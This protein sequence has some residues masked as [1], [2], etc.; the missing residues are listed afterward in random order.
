MDKR[1]NAVLNVVYSFQSYT[2]FS[3]PGMAGHQLL[4]PQQFPESWQPS[5]AVSTARQLQDSLS[6]AASDSHHVHA[7][8]GKL[9]HTEDSDLLQSVTSAHSSHRVSYTVDHKKRFGSVAIGTSLSAVSL[10]LSQPTLHSTNVVSCHSGPGHLPPVGQTLKLNSAS[11]ATQQCGDLSASSVS[12]DESLSE[13][14]LPILDDQII[15][16]VQV[17]VT[18]PA[19]QVAASFL[20]GSG[21]QLSNRQHI[22]L[23]NQL[24][25]HDEMDQ[26]K[27]GMPPLT[28]SQLQPRVEKS[29]IPQ[30]IG[31]AV[32][33]LQDVEDRE[34]HGNEAVAEF[35]L[36][37]VSIDQC[38]SSV[39]SDVS[40]EREVANQ[41]V[42]V[43]AETMSTEKPSKEEMFSSTISSVSS[44]SL[45]APAADDPSGVSEENESDMRDMKKPSVNSEN[46]QSRENLPDLSQYLPHEDVS[47][48]SVTQSSVRDELNM[49]SQSDSLQPGDQ[50]HVDVSHLKRLVTAIEHDLDVGMEVD[51]LYLAQSCS[52]GMKRRIKE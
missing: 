29:S 17:P 7:L 3:G 22:P 50:P 47:D 48:K 25:V 4:L 31:D 10:S 51:D 24:S 40:V 8:S 39:H 42:T 43:R 33:C 37:D 27:N 18:F 14:E 1:T 9:S 20:K 45:P 16:P 5:T 13:G 46:C 28:L 15:S 2:L 19:K 11:S 44:L 52:Q 6:W 32:E 30:S 36:E 49:S 34:T 35:Q 12:D 38:N 23:L 21:I 41:K 26:N